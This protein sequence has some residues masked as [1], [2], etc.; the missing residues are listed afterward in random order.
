MNEALGMI[1]IAL[2][3]VFVGVLIPVM[4]QLR[5]T[6]KSAGRTLDQLRP[7]L[8]R[9]LSEV[10]TATQRINRI[11]ANLEDGTEKL[12][13][14]FKEAGELGKSLTRLR[15]SLR[16]AEA[17]GRAVG[18]AIVAAVSAFGGVAAGSGGTAAPESAAE[19]PGPRAVHDE[20]PARRESKQGGADR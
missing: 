13:S 12:G 2:L 17:V 15:R 4:L 8:D 6:L 19:Q 5:H 16:T 7:K 10:S 9:T 14:V 11:A 3:A 18:P 20:D 1:G